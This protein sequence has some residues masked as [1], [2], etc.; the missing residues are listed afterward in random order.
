MPERFSNAFSRTNMGQ[1]INQSPPSAAFMRQWSGPALIE[2]MVCRLFGT[3]PLS[4]LTLIWYKLDPLEQ[5]SVKFE[6]KHKLFHSWKCIWKFRLRNGSHIVQRE[7]DYILWLCMEVFSLIKMCVAWKGWV[8]NIIPIWRT[9]MVAWLSAL[10]YLIYCT[11]S[12]WWL[13]SSE[14]IPNA[15]CHLEGFLIYG[16]MKLAQRRYGWY[17]SIK[18]QYVISTN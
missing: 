18:T 4:K 15:E 9:W 5:T 2:I 8:W 11:E 16:V 1:W 12:W 13:L 10:C 6:S 3:Q 14:S 17:I 7:I